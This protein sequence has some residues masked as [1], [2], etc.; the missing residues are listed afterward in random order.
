MLRKLAIALVAAISAAAIPFGAMAAHAGGGG[1]HGGGGGGGR[2]GG[3]GGG[4][5]GG[6][7]GGGGGGYSGGHSFSGGRGGGPG[8]SVRGMP[9]GNAFVNRGVNAQPFVNRGVSA[10]PFVSRGAPGRTHFVARQMSSDHRFAWIGHRRVHGRHLHGFIPGIG[11]AYY[12]YYDDCY[13]WTDDY[14]WVNICGYDY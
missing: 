12:W 4:Y 10:Q 5:S 7:S 13:V 9:G 2:G 3:G 6:H 14:G 11:Y 1:G 8:F